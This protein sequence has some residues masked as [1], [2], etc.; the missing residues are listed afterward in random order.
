M[1]PPLFRSRI[2]SGCGC[3]A[4]RP[5]RRPWPRPGQRIATL[6]A[7]NGKMGWRPG[8]AGMRIVG[9][10]GPGS[11]CPR[12][13]RFAASR[14]RSAT[15][16]TACQVTRCQHWETCSCTTTPT[17]A[18][19]HLQ[20][21][22]GAGLVPALRFA[23]RRQSGANHVGA[24]PH[25]A[26]H[27]AVVARVDSCAGRAAL[28]VAAPLIG[29]I[30]CDADIS[31]G[32]GRPHAAPTYPAA[33]KSASISAISAASLWNWRSIS[34]IARRG[35]TT[36]RIRRNTSLA[37]SAAFVSPGCVNC[38]PLMWRGRR[39]APGGLK[40]HRRGGWRLPARRSTARLR[41]AGRRRGGPV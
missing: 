39:A 27:H 5:V 34:R 15:G 26:G 36:K 16:R 1:S 18:D 3:P 6:T 30:C 7:K 41:C 13:K 11:N 32:D 33:S 29:R 2:Y 35:D 17:A 25:A 20:R 28:M 22:A 21:G 38:H 23:S 12:S 4:S 9:C 10:S 40:L 8:E 37:A 19:S 14:S 31:V 24:Q